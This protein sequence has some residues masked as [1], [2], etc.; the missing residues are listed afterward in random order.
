MRTEVTCQPVDT[1]APFHTQDTTPTSCVC[2][3]RVSHMN[4]AH[5][6]VRSDQAFFLTVLVTSD[7]LGGEEERRRQKVTAALLRR[8]HQH[9]LM[10][11]S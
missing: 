3:R 6:Q 2:T 5:D 9:D 7:A 10:K 8:T 11:W 4:R 1:R